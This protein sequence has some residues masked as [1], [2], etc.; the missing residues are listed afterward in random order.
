MASLK[1]SITKSITTLNVKTNNFMEQS[2]YKTYISTLE[3]DI[4]KLKFQI[5]AL[6]YEKWSNGEDGKEELEPLF[7]QI[8]SKY[9]E[10]SIQEE[11]IRK[12]YEE[13]Q[14]I[15]GTGS[16]A[17]VANNA[18]A[19]GIFCSQC[20]AKNAENYRFCVKCGSPLQ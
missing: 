4:K 3:E 9:K 2:K 10:I 1:E 5:G 18:A 20:G 11:N 14:Q 17:S 13:E 15:L 19:P 7:M 8:S 6:A 16:N 12:L